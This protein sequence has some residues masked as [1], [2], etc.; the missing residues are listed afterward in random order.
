MNP[1]GG[2]IFVTSRC[3]NQP[4]VWNGF[5]AGIGLVSVVEY[6]SLAWFSLVCFFK[7]GE[8]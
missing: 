6:G 8:F 7:F 3:K 4:S 5:S 2:Q 1:S